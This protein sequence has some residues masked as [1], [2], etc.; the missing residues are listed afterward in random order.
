MAVWRRPLVPARRCCAAVRLTISGG[1]RP[2]RARSFCVWASGSGR[3]V[4]RITAAKGASARTS[5]CLPRVDDDNGETG[6][7]QRRR[8]GPLQATG[9]FQH[10]Q[11]GVEGLHLFHERRDSIGIVRNGPPRS[12]GAH[13]HIPRGF[14]DINTNKSTAR[15]PEALLPARPCRYG[16]HGTRQLSG[17]EESGT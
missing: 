3:G 10:H 4:G 12:G 9:G 17:L 11:G 14:R 2:K 6:R 16:L 8:G 1:R 5:A 13:R 7:R 15:Q